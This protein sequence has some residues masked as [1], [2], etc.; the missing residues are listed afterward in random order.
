M[1]ENVYNRSHGDVK[2]I[3]RMP[4]KKPANSF[5]AALEAA[6]IRYGEATKER[7]V[8]VNKVADL[9]NELPALQ[10]TIAALQRQLHPDDVTFR[11]S[12]TGQETTPAGE[13]RIPPLPDGIPVEIAK[14]LV[15]DLSGMSSVPAVQPEKTEGKSAADK[16]RD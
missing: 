8:A 6:T 11:N 10:Q 14:H 5:A 4:R 13:V 9:D 12:K 15:L 2:E 7:E 16:E 1:Q 3:N